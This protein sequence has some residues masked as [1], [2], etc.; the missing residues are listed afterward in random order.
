MALTI[1]VGLVHSTGAQTPA[2]AAPTPPVDALDTDPIRCWWQTSKG[3]VRMGE[4]FTLLLTCAVLDN[5]AVQVVPDES[6]LASS[7]IQLSPFEVIDG[8][9]PAD[10]RTDTRRFLQYSYDLR[11]INPDLVGSDIRV[12][13]VTLHY[14]VSSRVG[15]STALQGRDQ[16]YVLPEQWVHVLSLVPFE[17]SDIRDSAGS[18]FESTEGLTYRASLLRIG[19]LTFA[20]LG[21][22]MALISL[23]RLLGQF[24]GPAAVSHEAL[25]QSGVKRLALR[26]LGA[27]RRDVGN[28]GWTAALV[29]RAAAA[30]R[31]A[32]TLAVGRSIAQRE[33]HDG[34]ASEGRVLLRIPW[35][36]FA[37]FAFSG[38]ATT[39]D[40][41]RAGARL[42]ESAS[43]SARQSLDDLRGALDAFTGAGYRRVGELDREALD[44]ALGLAL[45]GA[46]RVRV[47]PG[48]PLSLLRLWNTQA[49][50]GGRAA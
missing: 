20:V 34:D 28:G 37:P 12:P 21:V 15:G 40:L 43:A 10:L 22:L 31:L 49:S 16:T 17:A 39:A 42:P 8:G 23:V 30:T 2:P 18:P 48:W 29:D 44:A 33:A 3:A 1:M 36:R 47:A 24:R 13:D 32:G 5:D 19:A 6:R 45:S 38:S 25:G 9:H 35:R 7:V 41:E 50:G 46:R 11:V 27:V 14:R 26:E 4:P